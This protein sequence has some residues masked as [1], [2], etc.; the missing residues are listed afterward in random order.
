MSGEEAIEVEKRRK[1][2]D[3]DVRQL[4][5]KYLRIVEW[6]VPDTDEPRA[7]RLII[8]EIREAL[9]RLETQA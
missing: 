9:A 1:R 4:V 8:G 2:L 7:R 6:D 3:K 5:D